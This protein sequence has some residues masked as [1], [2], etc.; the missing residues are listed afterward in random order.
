MGDKPTT[1][2]RTKN[3]ETVREIKNAPAALQPVGAPKTTTNNNNKDTPMNV[4]DPHISSAG[5]Q[6]QQPKVDTTTILFP[7]IPLMSYDTATIGDFLTFVFG[8]E[9]NLAPDEEILTWATPAGKPPTYPIDTDSLLNGLNRTRQPRALYFGTSTCSR[10]PAD[11]GLYNRKSLFKRLFVVVLDDIGTKVDKKD[12][13]PQLKPTYIIETSA[14]NYQYGYVLSEPVDSLPAAEALINLAYTSGFSDEGGKMPTKL[15][16][17]PEGVNGKI[18]VKQGFVSRLVESEGPRWTPQALLDALGY[19]L[20]WADILADADEVMK[21]HK[22]RAVGSSP[23]S[24]TKAV[25]ASTTGIIDPVLE[26]LYAQREIVQDNGIWATVPCPFA[27]AHTSGDGTAGYCAIGRGDYPEERHFNCFH[28]SCS[29]QG[30]AE[31]LQYIASNGGPLAGVRDPIPALTAEYIYDATDDLVWRI[32][33]TDAPEN[34][35]L[36]AFRTSFPHKVTITAKDGSE[37]EVKEHALWVMSKARVTVSGRTFDPSTPARLVMSAGALRL[38]TFLP[39]LW[40][41][42]KPSKYHVKRFE[43]FLDYLIPTNIEREYFLD[44]L[45]AKVQDMSFRGAAMVMVA[46]AQG[47]GRSTLGDMIRTLFTPPNVESVPFD[48]L[49]G[50]AG[51]N[52]WQENPIVIT[53]ET[54]N[55][56]SVDRFKVYERLKELIDPRPQTIRINPKY[57]KQRI[58]TVCSSFMF[59]SNHANALAASA[60]DRRLYVIQNPDIPEEPSYY[61]ALNS[62]IDETGAD[63]KP[64]WAQ[65]IWYWLK[66]REVDVESLLKPP[67]ATVGKV[68]M[69]EETRSPVDTLLELVFANL[70]TE[71]VYYAVIEAAVARFE[72]R[73]GFHNMANPDVVIK[74]QF[75]RATASFGQEVSGTCNR[76]TIRPKLILS[77]AK[78]A[79]VRRP[80]SGAVG[81]ANVRHILDECRCIDLDLVLDRVSTALELLDI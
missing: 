4:S 24:P 46:T 53:N 2:C 25:A 35:S 29:H 8:D 70:D 47:T 79:E 30:T 81:K 20:D 49:V 48:R 19:I 64:I 31:Y 58:S 45:A 18:G 34:L 27:D 40:K 1:K 56:S 3:N 39:P 62:W 75:K 80:K 17:L 33:G 12:L 41:G 36:S 60:N 23:W 6:P 13:P 54:L 28:E 57:G 66:A 63:G 77:L 59:F 14:G 43:D 65:H 76:K 74:R 73:L 26:H 5:E 61:T 38:N 37:A 68:V 10:D 11:N 50:E 72:H 52:E 69:H 51:F 55:T 71:Y 9:N 67:A 21:R 16:R 42:V 78:N 44:W 22:G 15:V 32:R 7:D